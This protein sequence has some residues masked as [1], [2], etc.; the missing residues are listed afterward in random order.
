MQK[1]I[2]EIGGIIICMTENEKR[3]ILKW[4]WQYYNS[5]SK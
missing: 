4:F 2:Q 5:I 1:D 3:V